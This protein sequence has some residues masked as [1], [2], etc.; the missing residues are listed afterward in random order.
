MFVIF[1]RS[2]PPQAHFSTEIIKLSFIVYLSRC[3]NIFTR[4][5]FF[6]VIYHDGEIPGRTI[7]FFE[8][9][10]YAKQFKGRISFYFLIKKHRYLKSLKK[11]VSATFA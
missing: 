1:T 2:F 10:F 5:G 8:K 11:F 9:Y 4:N 6:L 3:I 7:S